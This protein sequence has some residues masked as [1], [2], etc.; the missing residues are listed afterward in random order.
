[1]K[2]VTSI[3]LGFLLT[4]AVAQAAIEPFSKI[5][6]EQRDALSKQ[7]EAYVNA[8]RTRDWSKFYTLVS[9]TGRGGVSK[10]TFVSAIEIGHGRSFA[11]EPD[12]LQFAPKLAEADKNDEYDVYGCA[13]AQREGKTYH[14]VAVLHAVFEHGG[15]FF[16]GWSFTEFPNEPCK[17]L[18]NPSWEPSSR[19]PWEQPMEELRNLSG[20][21][22]H[23]EAPKR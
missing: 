23:V 6:G 18:S 14:G 21:P 5:S 3:A 19:M 16:T 13:K 22:F 17:V 15:W 7:I 8:N 12:L 9:D 20:V 2:T 10:E 4:L 11:N 1:M